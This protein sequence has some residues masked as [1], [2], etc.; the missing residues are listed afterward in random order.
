[1]EIMERWELFRSERHKLEG[2]VIETEGF[3]THREGLSSVI[4]EQL[5]IIKRVSKT[6]VFQDAKAL[7][8]DMNKKKSEVLSRIAQIVEKVNNMH[9]DSDNI[10]ELSGKIARNI[11]HRCVFSKKKLLISMI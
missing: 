11:V 1:M 9:L 7:G 3:E 2:G 4:Q 6:P 5:N 10:R 8:Q